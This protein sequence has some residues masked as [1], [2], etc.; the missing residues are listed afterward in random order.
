MYKMYE[1]EGKLIKWSKREDAIK[2]IGDASDGIVGNLYV[3]KAAFIILP[4]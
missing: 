2:S 1:A 3:F 4:N